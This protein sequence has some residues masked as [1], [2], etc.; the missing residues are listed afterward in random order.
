MRSWTRSWL[1]GHGGGL[2]TDL[3]PL[4]CSACCLIESRASRPGMAPPTMD[5]DLPHWSL[6]KK[7]P[8]SLPYTLILWRHFLS[9]GSLLSDDS[10]LCQADIKLA[11]T[12]RPII[13]FLPTSVSDLTS[14]GLRGKT[15]RNVLKQIPGFLTTKAQNVIR[16]HPRLE[17]EL[18]HFSG[19]CLPSTPTDVFLKCLH[20][21]LSLLRYY[22][23]LVKLISGRSR[24]SR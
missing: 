17:Q 20:L 16:H 11:S 6:I 3:L 21:W 5:W 22:E 1:R 24:D 4:A 19:T 18:P 7:M 10:S 23:N 8:Y 13:H 9:W 2:L 12:G 14:S 15:C